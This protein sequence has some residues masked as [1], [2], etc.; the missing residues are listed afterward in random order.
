MRAGVD[1]VALERILSCRRRVRNITLGS[2]FDAGIRETL[3]ED[4]SVQRVKAIIIE[5]SN[6]HVIRVS[7]VVGM[8]F[9]GVQTSRSK[10]RSKIRSMSWRFATL[11]A[12]LDTPFNIA[13]GSRSARINDCI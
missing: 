3:L 5:R 11:V 2:V 13:D 9:R 6:D 8:S 4:V 7:R 1:E 10:I 12:T